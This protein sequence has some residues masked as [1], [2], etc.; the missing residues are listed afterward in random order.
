MFFLFFFFYDIKLRRQNNR[1]EY[2]NS[3]TLQKISIILKVKH[4]GMLL[5]SHNELSIIEIF[6]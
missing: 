3:I 5:M 1:D 4:F 6:Y 2:Q